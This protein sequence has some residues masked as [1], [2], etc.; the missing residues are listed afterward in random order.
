MDEVLQEILLK[1]SRQI[2]EFCNQY[3][4]YI[5][6]QGMDKMDVGQGKLA[7]GML[8]TKNMS[9]LNARILARDVTSELSGV[10]ANASN[11]TCPVTGPHTMLK[12]NLERLFLEARFTAW[13]VI[14]KEINDGK[15]DSRFL[16][17]KGKMGISAPYT[18][19]ITCLSVS[20]D[21][22]PPSF[23]HA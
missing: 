21:D 1:S 3:L 5:I 13:M 19:L 16:L 7:V 9:V 11:V 18:D 12:D 2:E 8:V 17:Y 23:E 10:R 6:P 4:I 20:S 14:G 15:E 22:L